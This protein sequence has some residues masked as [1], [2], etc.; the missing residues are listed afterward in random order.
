MRANNPWL[1][2]AENHQPELEGDWVSRREASL[3]AYF[4]WM[5]VRDPLPGHDRSAYWRRYSFGDLASIITL[6]T[7][8]TGRAQQID[9]GDYLSRFESAEDARWFSTEVLGASGRDML[10]AENERFV[11]KGLAASIAAGQPWRVIANQIPMARVNVPDLSGTGL[12]PDNPNP[13]DPVASALAELGRIGEFDLPIYLDTWDGYPEARERFY[14]LCREVGAQDLLVVTGDSH[15]FWANALHDAQGQSMGLE[16]GT[17]GISSPGDFERLG[18]EDSQLMDALLAAHNP[19]VVWTD[20]THRGYIRVV[21]DHQG[22]CADYVAVTNVLDRDYEIELV[23][24]VALA[25]AKGR[26]SFG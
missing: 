10:S 19:E 21:L 17:T 25:C 13:K 12:I 20:N 26:L 6:E 3:Q 5:P 4:E 23:K 7:R 2:G 11:R 14:A 22:G 8:H 18:P 15:A 24:R 16:L 1:K 9:Y